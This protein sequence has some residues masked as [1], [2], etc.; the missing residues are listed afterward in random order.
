VIHVRA[1]LARA[2]ADTPAQRVPPKT[3]SAIRDIPLVAQLAKPLR[4]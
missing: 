4:E 1:Q 2:R 3:A